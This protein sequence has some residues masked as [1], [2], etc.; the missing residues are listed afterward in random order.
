V[1]FSLALFSLIILSN[2]FI[3]FVHSNKS[4]R[5]SWRWTSVSCMLIFRFFYCCRCSDELEADV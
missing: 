1:W 3:V 5:N 2:D 4:W